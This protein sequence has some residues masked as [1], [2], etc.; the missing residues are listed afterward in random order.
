MDHC[1]RREYTYIWK[2]KGIPLIQTDHNLLFKK[3]IG[4]QNGAGYIL[5]FLNFNVSFD[6]SKA[7]WKLHMWFLHNVLG[8]SDACITWE[9]SQWVIG[10][11]AGHVE[12][13]RMEKSCKKNIN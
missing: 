1:F 7:E 6:V 3:W 13:Q 8:L 12:K 11:S 4:A 5:S 2:F 9:A 10:T